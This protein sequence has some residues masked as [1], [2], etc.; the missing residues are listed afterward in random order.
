LL[1]GW[2][3]TCT[4]ASLGMP[5]LPHAAMPA[6]EKKTAPSAA[7]DLTGFNTTRAL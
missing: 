4:T 1:I 6:T 7:I 3:L 2:P 5:L